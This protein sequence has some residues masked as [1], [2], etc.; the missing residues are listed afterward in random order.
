MVRSLGSGEGSE[1]AV[2][3]LLVSREP[4]RP[5]SASPWRNT[6]AR[7]EF[8]PMVWMGTILGLVSGGSEEGV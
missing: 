5:P 2:C 4:A 6:S 8:P 1:D 7:G 3:G